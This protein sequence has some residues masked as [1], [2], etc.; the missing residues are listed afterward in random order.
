MGFKGVG[1]K[2]RGMDSRWTIAR[3]TL[4]AKS[5]ASRCWMRVCDVFLKDHEDW[6]SD[7]RER[8]TGPG[9]CLTCQCS[10]W[11]W[12]NLVQQCKDRL[13]Y[14]ASLAEEDWDSECRRRNVRDEKDV[15]GVSVKEVCIRASS[16]FFSRR[17]L[18]LWA[19]CWMDFLVEEIT[20]ESDAHLFS[21]ADRDW[22]LCWEWKRRLRS[23][24]FQTSCGLCRFSIQDEMWPR[25]E[26]SSS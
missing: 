22:E 5:S 7:A 11:Y 16:F 26:R 12:L 18:K 15:I 23:M 1:T 17:I 20:S 6:S 19:R 9:N 10:L 8:N 3:R 14:A 25:T 24:E 4:I 21:C 13:R 2:S